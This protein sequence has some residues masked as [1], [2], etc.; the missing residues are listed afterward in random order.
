M[1]ASHGQV[2][3][4]LV[5]IAT[6]ESI[7]SASF[8]SYVTGFSGIVSG[9]LTESS[10]MK[11]ESALPY[12]LYPGGCTTENSVG[13]NCT[14]AC[15][16]S[17]RIFSSPATFHNCMVAPYIIAN[18][19]GADPASVAIAHDFGI[20]SNSVS[21]QDLSTII[22]TCFAS[23]CDSSGLCLQQVSTLAGSCSTNDLVST[24]GSLNGAAV[25]N[26][27]LKMCSTLP[28]EV[29]SDLGGI[30]V[31]AFHFRSCISS[32]IAAKQSTPLFYL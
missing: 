15:G 32:R 11:S 8:N 29:D 5:A 10:T 3:I 27:M 17:S 13:D 21:F 25:S 16:D 2:P 6:T 20:F 23:Y 28:L 4:P 22:P 26:C 7:D 19:S 12:V 14:T 18:L 9:S 24:D 31:C 30:G 1:A